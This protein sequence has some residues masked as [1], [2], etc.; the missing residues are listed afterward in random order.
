LASIVRFFE[1]STKRDPPVQARREW[2]ESHVSEDV[3]GSFDLQRED[4]RPGESFG[5]DQNI[6][7]AFDK[8]AVI[9]GTSQVVVILNPP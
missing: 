8:L 6:D 1:G 7:G 9:F 3:D 2:V 5:R 4:R